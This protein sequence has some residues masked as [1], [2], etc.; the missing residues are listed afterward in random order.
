MFTQYY[1]L[2]EDNKD[3]IKKRH[4]SKSNKK[5]QN[6]YTIKYKDIQKKG[7]N[8]D[9]DVTFNKEDE[10]MHDYEASLKIGKFWKDKVILD[11]KNTSGRFAFHDK[12][13][14]SIV[15]S[16]I[17][18]LDQDTLNFIKAIHQEN[19]SIVNFA[20]NSFKNELICSM[21]NSLMRVFNVET[22]KCIKAWKVSDT[23]LNKVE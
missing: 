17:H 22:G 6:N 9:E 23:F 18:V 12:Q 20:H 10:G 16:K 7:Q 1:L 3:F 15:G 2:M 11:P 5:G 14:F 19:E 13:I 4:R 21:D 8:Y